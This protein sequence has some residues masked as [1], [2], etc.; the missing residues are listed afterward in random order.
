MFQVDL[1]NLD[2]LE[3]AIEY[4][5]HSQLSELEMMPYYRFQKKIKQLSDYLKKK[6][7]AEEKGSKDSKS[8]YNPSSEASKMMKQAKPPSVKMPNVKFPK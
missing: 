2:D 5:M 4:H 3:F 1:D 6:K 8:S 7:E